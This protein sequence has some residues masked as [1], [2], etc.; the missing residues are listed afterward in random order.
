MKKKVTLYF[1]NGETQTFIAEDCSVSIEGQFETPKQVILKGV[2]SGDEFE[3]ILWGLCVRGKP[4][5]AIR[6]IKQNFP[7]VGLREAKNYVY[8]LRDRA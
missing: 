4:L 5:S 6:L 2:V 1:E 3:A 8:A 7:E